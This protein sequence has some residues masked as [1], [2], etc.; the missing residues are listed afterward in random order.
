MSLSSEPAS[1]A[2]LERSVGSR[3][4]GTGRRSDGDD[5]GTDPGDTGRDEGE[6]VVDEAAKE[7]FPASDPPSWPSGGPPEPPPPQTDGGA[8]DAV[9][10]RPRGATAVRTKRQRDPET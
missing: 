4:S 1:P 2:S 7:S 10:D 5:P 8:V 3:E 9:S 6:D